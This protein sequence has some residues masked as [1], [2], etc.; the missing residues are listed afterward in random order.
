MS[1]VIPP[2]QRGALDVRQA[3]EAAVK[4]IAQHVWKFFVGAF[5]I[6]IW[7]IT[8]ALALGSCVYVGS[9]MVGLI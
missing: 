7:L 9:A 8:T 4:A 2:H 3:A 1:N 6:A 5:A